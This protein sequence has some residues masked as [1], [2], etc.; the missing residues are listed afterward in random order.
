M[1]TIVKLLEKKKKRLKIKTKPEKIGNVPT[2]GRKHIRHR[3]PK[4][5]MT[6]FSSET[7]QVRR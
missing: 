6:V 3:K 4:I 7:M 5:K 1:H 2:G